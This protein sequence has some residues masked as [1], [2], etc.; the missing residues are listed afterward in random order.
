MNRW[1]LNNLATWEL[2]LLIVGGFVLVVLANPLKLAGAA[3]PLSVFSFDHPAPQ[4]VTGFPTTAAWSPIT[5]DPPASRVI[6]ST[7]TVVSPLLGLCVA[8]PP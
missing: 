8:S 6:D 4:N 5:N 1:L 3:P 2:G 7:S